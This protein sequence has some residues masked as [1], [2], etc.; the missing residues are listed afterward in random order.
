MIGATSTGDGKSIG[1]AARLGDNY[2]NRKSWM[3]GT[4]PA[5][6]RVG[7]V[8]MFANVLIANRG[9]IACRVI[10]T[11]RRM[12]LRTIAW[13]RRPIAARCM[14]GSPTRR[15][16]SAKARDGYL[17]GA[18][19]VAL[20]KKVG[21]E[22]LHPGYGFLSENADFAELCGAAGL[23]F[24]GPSPA[25]MRA[26]GLKSAAKALMAKLGVPIA[27]G[28]HGDNQSREVPQ[29]EGLRD[30]LSRADQ[31]GRRRRRPRHAAGRRP[32]RVRAGARGGGARSGERLRRPA[33]AD[34]EIRRRA[35]P[36]RGP[37]VRRPRTAMSSI[38]SSA[39]AR[40]SAA[41]RRWSRKAR[42]LDC[43]RKR[44]RRCARPRSPRRAPSATPAPARSNSWSIRRA[45]SGPTASISSR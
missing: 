1:R 39:S 7:V 4:S 17:D 31:G 22:C 9:E 13:R 35:A 3:A 33:G 12:G 24:V 11:A 18:A 25:A 30:R 29:G 38:C 37:G 44:A 20:A 2:T 40:C 27:P 6:T 5:M 15:T 10:R 16:R 8:A 43:R 32:R 34:R 36:Y 42:R 26:L 23:V 14:C 41:I 19:I 45:A 28:Y 21:A